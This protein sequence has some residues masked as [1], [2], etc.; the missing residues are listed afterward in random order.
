MTIP[1]ILHAILLAFVMALV[2]PAA[3]GAQTGAASIT[4]LV[5]DDSGAPVP[6]VTVT[7][8]NQATNI[9]Y[10]AVSNEAGNYTITSVP[11]G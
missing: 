6:G 4:G 3:A 7:A 1:R 9:T 10:L 8:I 5:T 11:V 2:A